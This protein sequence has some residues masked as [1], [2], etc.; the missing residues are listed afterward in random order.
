MRASNAPVACERTDGN[1]LKTVFCPLAVKSLFGVLEVK[2]ALG[3][4]AVHQIASDG[5]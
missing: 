5:R 1:W 4:G 3:A 2:C